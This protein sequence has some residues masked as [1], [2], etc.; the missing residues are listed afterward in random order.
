M[1]SLPF[2]AAEMTK[3]L[4]DVKLAKTQPDISTLFDDR[5]IK[6]YSEGKS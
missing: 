6:A 3:F 4:V 5:F 2:A 1:T